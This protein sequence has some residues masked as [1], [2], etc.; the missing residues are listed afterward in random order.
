[1]TSGVKVS[2]IIP[3]YNAE[4]YLRQCLDSVV[5][6]TLEDIEIITVNDGSTDGSLTILEEYVALDPRIRVITQENGGAGRAR[7]AGMDAANGDYLSFLDADDFF[8]PNMLEEAYKAAVSDNADVSAFKSDSYYEDEDRFAYEKWTLLMEHVPPYLPFN[9][10]QLTT[11]VFRTFI[12]WAWDKIFKREFV[13]KHGLRFQEQRTTNDLLF[14]YSAILL[15]KR[16]TV[17]PEILAHQRRTS[18]DSLSKTREKSWDNFYNALFALRETLIDNNIHDELE[19]DFINYALHFTIWNYKTLAKPT[20]KLMGNAI[21]SGRFIE[22]GIHGKPESYFSDNSERK[23]YLL[24]KA[25]MRDDSEVGIELRLTED[26]SKYCSILSENKKDISI[27]ICSRD[28]IGYS[29]TL[30]AADALLSLGFKTDLH[31]TRGLAGNSHRAY[32]ARMDFGKVVFDSLRNNK[33]MIYEDGKLLVESTIWKSGKCS[34]ARIIIGGAD[35]CVN[36][37]GLNIVVIDKKRNVIDSV[38]FDYQ[39]HEC[40]IVR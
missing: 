30:E 27:I 8:E 11:N 33:D 28:N 1:M 21:R 36:K 19:K 5:A 4:Q 31:R 35:Y 13:Q 38:C 37:R 7:N 22:L 2:V 29:M 25:I 3:V 14:V 16:I 12:G 32:I 34:N 23:D 15:A 17:V 39:K 9:Y 20:Q 10:R 6:Q 40:K 26:L 24:Y 18:K